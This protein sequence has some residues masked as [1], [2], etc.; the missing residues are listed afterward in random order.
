MSRAIRKRLTAI[1]YLTAV[2]ALP[3]AVCPAAA[4][5]SGPGDGGLPVP[6]V[7]LALYGLR[8]T[9]S[10]S[11]ARQFSSAGWGGGVRLVYSPAT[12]AHGLGGALGFD[13]ANLLDQTT[14]L[15]D[16]HTL[17]RVEQNTSQYFVRF[18]L[19]GEIGPHGRGFFRPFAGAN[20]ALHVYTIGTSLTIPDDNDPSRSIYQN[21]G[22]ETHGA[23]GYDL[24]L[25]T[26]LQ[27]HRYS[28]EGGMRFLKSF[29]VP[30][31]LGRADAVFIHPGYVQAF[32]GVAVTAR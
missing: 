20:V 17:V 10:G 14:I 15:V 5:P 26:D 4:Q 27:Y 7:K 25:G 6:T 32:I 18:A 8:I 22:S 3:P 19:G 24:A 2:L 16:P 29:N 1:A 21:L 31:Q 11:D 23:F 12:F 30:Q 13:V 28:L 9:P